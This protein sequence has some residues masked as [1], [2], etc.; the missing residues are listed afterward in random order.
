MIDQRITQDKIIDE[1]IADQN[2]LTFYLK[3]GVSVKGTVLAHDSFTVYLKQ[4]QD[5]VLI[6]KHFL[7]S[8]FPATV[9]KNTPEGELTAD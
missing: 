9:H 5:Y 2:V 1:A 8:V 6:Y 7:T 4:N 3:S